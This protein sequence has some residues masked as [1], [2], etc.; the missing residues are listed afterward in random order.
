MTYQMFYFE[1]FVLSQY[2][3]NY[4]YIVYAVDRST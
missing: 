4:G 1:I 2:V 3:D